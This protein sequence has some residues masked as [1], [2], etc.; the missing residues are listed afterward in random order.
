MPSSNNTEVVALITQKLRQNFDITKLNIIDKSHLHAN[1]A[2]SKASGGGHFNLEMQC[3]KLASMP[4]IQAHK[5][6]YSC[7]DGL[8]PDKIHALSIKIYKSYYLT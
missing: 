3:D 5:A 6:I 1:H 4:K 7:L 2:S 8:F